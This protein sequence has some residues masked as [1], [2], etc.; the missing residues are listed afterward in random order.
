MTVR[1]LL[2]LALA[3][4]LAACSQADDGVRAEPTL[5]EADAPEA[6]AAPAAAPARNS[7]APP[8]SAYVGKHPTEPVQG[9]TFFQ[10]PDV[11]AAIVAS[12]VDRDIQK[13]IVF[14]GNVVGVVT[15]TRGRLLLHGYDPAG[16]GSTNWAILMI[17]DGSKAAVCYSTGIVGYEKGADWYFEGDVAFTLYTPC[18]SEEGD[19][20]SLS[21]WPIGP[22]P[23]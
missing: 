4:T 21:N 16:A 13:S 11:R 7:E 19:M 23:G 8:L 10:H 20:E 5:A 17:P 12:G 18:P 3:A 2:A 14:D 1:T 9:V 22:I 6:S 15:E